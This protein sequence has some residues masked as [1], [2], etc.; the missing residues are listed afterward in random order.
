MIDR[1]NMIFGNRIDAATVS[2]A[3]KSKRSFIKKFGNDANAVYHLGLEPISRI[4]EIRMQ[5]LVFADTPLT[6]PEKA[7]VVGN[8]RM[9]FG[10]YRISMAI[11]SCAQA[12]GYSP[13]WFDL[14]SFDATGSKMI[15]A[16]NDL[17]TMGSKVSQRSRLFNKVF[18]EPMN[19][20]G[21]RKLS[22]NAVDQKNAELLV[23]LYGDLPKDVPFVATHVWPS[24][25]AVHAGLTRVVN[26]IPDNWPMALHLSE[27]AV[28][29]VQTPFAYLGYKS[30]NG[31]AKETLLPMPEGSLYEVGHYVDH[32]LVA[33]LEKDCAARIARSKDGAPVRFLLTVGG[34]G[35]GADLYVAMT[36][37]LLSYVNKGQAEVIINLGDHLDM[38]EVFLKKI[39]EMDG[40][41]RRFFDD[42]EG[43]HAWAEEGD[44]SGVTAIYNRDIFEA[45]YSTNLFM[46]SCDVLVTK[47]SELAFYPVPKLFMRHIGG[48]EVYAGLHAQ[49][50]GEATVECMTKDKLCG[51]IDLLIANRE[52]LQS[53]NE[54]I[55]QNKSAG[56]YDGGYK[57][58]LLAA[59]GRLE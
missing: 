4:S 31:M 48:H 22:Y 5:N 36:K 32:E 6:L 3:E 59:E 26:A 49:E 44:F 1:T 8:I 24:Q 45:V 58:V 10:H 34:A 17:Y 27:G 30:L 20:E 2:K 29:T 35:A 37:H 21:F 52:L 57:A 56:M 43:L 15:R 40:L 12:L 23:P 7:L 39:P 50:A 33:D 51:M 14:A 13:V 25:G 42:Y 54:K 38:W 46:R 41:C 53:M 28:H 9:G 18:W 19:S 11:A 47:P 55:I 16:Q